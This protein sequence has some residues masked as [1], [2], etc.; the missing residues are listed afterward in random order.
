MHLVKCWNRNSL[1]LQAKKID[2]SAKSLGA[3]FGSLSMAKS[4]DLGGLHT[5]NLKNQSQ[6]A[7]KTISL[8]ES[9]ARSNSSFKRL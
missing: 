1:G 4:V 8:L 7:D 3:E 2:Y 9:K 6:G 5:L